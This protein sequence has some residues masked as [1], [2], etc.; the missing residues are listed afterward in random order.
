MRRIILFVGIAA[1]V[2]E[3]TD[4]A[5]DRRKARC[6]LSGFASQDPSALSLLCRCAG[7]RFMFGRIREASSHAQ[8]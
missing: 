6:Q 7:L 1:G 8:V 5:A 2:P 3:S 4:R